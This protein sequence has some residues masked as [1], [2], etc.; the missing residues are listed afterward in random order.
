MPVFGL[1]GKEKRVKSSLSGLILC[2]REPSDAAKTLV[3]SPVP[4][5]AAVFDVQ[6]EAVTGGKAGE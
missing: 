1:G 3:L 6:I 2:R 5:P 4:M